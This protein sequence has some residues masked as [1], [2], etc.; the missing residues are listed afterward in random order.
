NLAN[1]QC[2]SLSEV[3]EI[4]I[5][6]QPSAPV[7]NGDV[8]SC[9]GESESVS[10][11]V[12]NNV[13]VNWFDSPNGGNLLLSDNPIYETEI[14]DVYYA[15]AVS[16]E[17]DCISNARTPVRVTFLPVPQVEDESTFIC[18]GQ[19]KTLFANAPNNAYLWSTGDTVSQTTV[20]AP[21]IYTVIITN[22]SG[23]SV[24]KTITV[25]KIDT[26][27]IGSVVSD[28]DDIIITTVNSGEYEYSLDGG[29]Y[30]LNNRFYN[31]DGGLYT[32]SVRERNGCGIAILEDFIHFVIPKFFTPNDDT[33]NDLFVLKGIEFFDHSQVY[34]F[35]R[36]GKLLATSKNQPFYWDGTFK[37]K[38][39]PSS[40]YWYVVFIDGQEFKGHF[41]L[42]R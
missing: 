7:S 22:G 14:A 39:M 27:V 38:P 21:G 16:A 42:K 35:D 28:G 30:Q 18:E 33:E 20:N 23:C 37:N 26:P 36:Q 2:S 29:S 19:S 25:R 4:Q 17:G 15:E 6:P 8:T 40:D 41:T 10:V 9:G 13:I 12:P 31:V 1:P 34:I 32:I 3:F 11:T 5:L 24:T